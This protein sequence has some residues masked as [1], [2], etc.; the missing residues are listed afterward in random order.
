[1]ATRPVDLAYPVGQDSQSAPSLARTGFGGAVT[2]ARWVSEGLA[3][4]VLASNILVI[5]V[6][7]STVSAS[8]CWC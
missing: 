3:R 4:T 5:A 8:T 6:L 7:V 1:M 2:A